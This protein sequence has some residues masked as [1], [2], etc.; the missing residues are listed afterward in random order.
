MRLL[1]IV[2]LVSLIL[3]L[4]GCLKPYHFDGD[5]WKDKV[6]ARDSDWEKEV[7]KK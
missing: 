1:L 5:W 6:K 2:L 3:P 4:A 7:K